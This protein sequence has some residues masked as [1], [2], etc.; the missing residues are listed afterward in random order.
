LQC[1]NIDQ[2]KYY[3]INYMDKNIAK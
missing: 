1:T 2:N 3:R